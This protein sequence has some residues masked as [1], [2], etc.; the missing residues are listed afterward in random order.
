M[1]PPHIFQTVVEHL[2]ARELPPI[3]ATNKCLARNNKTPHRANATK[4]RKGI[5]GACHAA[6][7]QQ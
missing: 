3:A 4:K 1:I 7:P 6:L 5:C 2:L